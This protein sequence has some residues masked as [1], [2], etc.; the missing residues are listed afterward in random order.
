M[1]TCSDT[2]RSVAV[3]SNCTAARVPLAPPPTTATCS[4]RSSGWLTPCIDSS[5]NYYPGRINRQIR[6]RALSKWGTPR[7]GGP[8]PHSLAV[9][10]G[11]SDKPTAKVQETARE[12]LQEASRVRLDALIT[13][14][15]A[16]GAASRGRIAIDTDDAAA[17]RQDSDGERVDSDAVPR[18]Y[19]SRRSMGKLIGA[20]AVGAAAA[21]ALGALPA[22]AEESQPQARATTFRLFPHTNGPRVPRGGERIG[23]Q[24]ASRHTGAKQQHLPGQRPVEHGEVRVSLQLRQQ[25]QRREPL[26]GRRGHPRLIPAQAPDSHA[27]AGAVA[28]A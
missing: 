24:R 4:S 5:I 16:F 23:L 20:A 27:A 26:G 21:G 22:D 7:P 13:A 1:V 9:S 14:A 19:V 12:S 10:C 25:G 28:F 17:F 6:H 18:T 2:W 8:T 3:R 15:K 11:K